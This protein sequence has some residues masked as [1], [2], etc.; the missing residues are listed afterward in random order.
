MSAVIYVRVSTEEQAQHGYSLDAQEELC[1]K[2][3]TELGVDEVYLYREEGVS[4]E[5]LE[6]PVLQ[7]ALRKVEEGAAFFICYD[8]D[9]LSRKLAHQLIITDRIEKAGCKLE[10]V[11]FEWKDTPEGRLFYSLRGAIAE[12]EKEKIKARSKLGRIAKAKRGEIEHIVQPYGY[13]LV[14]KNGSNP[15]RLEIDESQAAVVRKIFQWAAMGLRGYTIAKKLIEEGIPAPRGGDKWYRG[16]VDRIRK[17]T[18]YTGVVF[19]NRINTEGLSMNTWL[20]K[21]RRKKRTLRPREEWIP[22][23]VPAIVDRETWQEAQIPRRQKKRKYTY[24]LAGLVYCGRCGSSL[25]G[26]SYKNKIRKVYTYYLCRYNIK[27]RLDYK[28]K[29]CDL[30]HVP[31]EKLEQAVWEQ[32]AL[33]L[34]DP[35]G[36]LEELRSPQNVDDLKTE[37]R[38]VED[39]MK[40]VKGEYERA[41]LAFTKGWVAKDLFEKTASDINRRLKRLEENAA[42]LRAAI[43]TALKRKLDTDGL[44]KLAYEYSLRIDSLSF[45]E[46][47]YLVQCLVRRVIVNGP[48]SVDIYLRIRPAYLTAPELLAASSDGCVREAKDS[49]G[50][51]Y[52]D[53]SI[54]VGDPVDTP[55]GSVII[56]VSRVTFGFAAGGSEFPTGDGNEGGQGGTASPEEAGFPFGGGSG[57]G[58][59][60]QPVAFLVVGQGTVRLLSVEGGA[61]LDRLIDIAPQVINRIESAIGG[62][63]TAA[64]ERLSFGGREYRDNRM[65]DRT[66]RAGDR[67]HRRGT[68]ERGDRTEEQ[69]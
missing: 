12:Y 20:P 67:E 69:Q 1:R 55:D 22:I 26:T 47:R 57:A 61:L 15:T 11:N 59:T 2:K 13:R 4:G 45:E 54:V 16:T 58:V 7:E 46:K 30:P 9:R 49:Y 5:L 25:Y 38:R 60:V 36:L 68:H 28:D 33:V 51:L 65:N 39:Q 24:L 21:H 18:A 6:R 35:D 64:K 3:A 53:L 19:V 66:E 44:R 43:N 17:N 42:E 32:V 14:P 52:N 31:A 37:L 63:G 50:C 62:L 41:F 29:V 56:P 27:N 40:N 34:K 8:P 10:F 23:E 48:D